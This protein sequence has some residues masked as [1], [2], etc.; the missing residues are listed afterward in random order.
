MTTDAPKKTILVVED[1][2]LVNAMISMELEDVGYDVLSADS[3]DAALAWF[4]NGRQIDLLFT[5]I[6]LA[7]SMD[8]WSVARK[9]RQLRPGLK[10]V[11]ATGYTPSAADLVEGARFFL[12]PYLPTQFIAVVGEMLG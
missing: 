12:K 3:G 11:Y 8:G 4:A 10:I 9:A 2:F 5:D 1:E 6:K 7:G